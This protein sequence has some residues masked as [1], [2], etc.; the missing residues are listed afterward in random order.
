MTKNEHSYEVDYADR[1]QYES[2]DFLQYFA[3]RSLILNLPV[4]KSHITNATR[5][6]APTAISTSVRELAILPIAEIMTT[7]HL[8]WAKSVSSRYSL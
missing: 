5:A 3:K 4:S 6:I 8:L 7:P 2:T 1:H